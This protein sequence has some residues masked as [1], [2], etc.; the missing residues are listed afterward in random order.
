MLSLLKS[1]FSLILIVF[2]AAWFRGR[3][4]GGSVVPGQ[5]PVNIS[6]PTISGTPQLG[7]TLTSQSGTWTNNPTSY[8]DRWFRGGTPIVGA[9]AFS[10]V[11]QQADAG[12]TLR[13]GEIA[14]NSA[15]SRAEALSVAPAAVSIPVPVIASLPTITGSNVNGQTLTGAHGNWANLQFTPVSYADQWFRGSN[16]ISGATSLTYV[17]Q[18]ADVGSNI[19]LKEIATNAGGPSLQAASTPT[20][21]IL[22]LAPVNVTLP[23]IAGTA[24]VGSS[25][26][27]THGTW[28]YSPLSYSDQW[29][30]AGTPIAGATFLNYTPVV[31]D[32]GSTLTVVETASNSGGQ[33][34]PA[35]SLPTLAV[36]G[37]T[38]SYLGTQTVGTVNDGGGDAGILNCNSY[39]NGTTGAIQSMSVYSTTAVAGNS[40]VLAVY[41]A[42]S[43]SPGALIAQTAS[44][45]AVTVGWMTA[46]TTTPPTLTSG[47]AYWLCYIPSS[48]SALIAQATPRTLP[49]RYHTGITYPTLPNPMGTTLNAPAG[50]SGAY[51]QYATIGGGGGHSFVSCGTNPTI[52]VGTQAWYNQTINATWSCQTDNNGQYIIAVHC[53]SLNV[54]DTVSFDA[55]RNMTCAQFA[56]SDNINDGFHIPFNASYHYRYSFMVEV[57]TSRELSVRRNYPTTPWRC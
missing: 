56:S 48:G 23:T 25:L 39:T 21:S 2:V 17:L 33:S 27:A 35:T 30:K 32:V 54:C 14:T 45:S 36:T 26:V 10:Y 37:N 44:T 43:G 28:T 22:D 31:G 8:A 5:V 1:I 41:A 12:F 19:T 7:Q 15:G 40:Y 51:S 16:P 13:F 52:Q 57:S 38:V 49:V 20:S 4:P 55:G 11:I 6:V 18:Q 53:T 34:A 9:T 42:S 46:N 50:N 24:Q 47:T 3:P 29:Y